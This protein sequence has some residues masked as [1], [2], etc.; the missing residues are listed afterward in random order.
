M[1]P[2]PQYAYG[3]QPLPLEKLVAQAAIRRERLCKMPV[4]LPAEPCQD[5]VIP[6]S[7]ELYQFPDTT[8]RPAPLLPVAHAD[9]PPQPMIQLTRIVVL[10]GDAEVVHP[11]LS[12]EINREINRD[13]S[14]FLDT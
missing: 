2:D 10:H 7:T 11:S 12:V 1:N 3:R 9:T 13:T 8:F 4:A 6:W 5:C 14:H